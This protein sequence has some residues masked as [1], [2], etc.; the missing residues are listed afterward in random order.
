M[1]QLENKTSYFWRVRG[2]NEAGGGD[3]RAPAMLV[4][5]FVKRAHF[6]FLTRIDEAAFTRALVEAF[7]AVEFWDVGRLDR[8]LIERRIPALHLGETLFAKARLARPGWTCTL[9]AAGRPVTCAW[10]S[11]MP[12][13]NS[14]IS[15]RAVIPAGAT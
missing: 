9:T 12:P 10:P 4:I 14:S 1:Q 5:D 8:K 15:S 6:V 2:L 13:Q 11:A 3:Y 7:P